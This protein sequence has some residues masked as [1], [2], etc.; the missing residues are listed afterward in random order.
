MLASLEISSLPVLLTEI[1]G[2]RPSAVLDR[3]RLVL[4]NVVF[5]RW[6]HRPAECVCTV[7]SGNE[8]IVAG[9]IEKGMVKAPGV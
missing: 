1:G 8:S 3:G 6:F 7:V 2:C 5:A 4:A 9:D